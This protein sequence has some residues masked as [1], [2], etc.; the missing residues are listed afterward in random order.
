MDL[1]KF[2][3]EKATVVPVPSA[4]DELG[5]VIWNLEPGQENAP[6]MH[7]LNGHAFIVLEGGGLFLNGEPGAP[8]FT[9]EPIKVGNV[10]M[11][12]RGNIHGIRN[13]GTV[14]FSYC[15]LTST[16]DGHGYTRVPDFDH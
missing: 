2:S 7:P 14:N 10:I 8:D 9:E 13:T 1:R 3:P 5:M 4:P 6:H 15:A 16:Q 12:P 11:I